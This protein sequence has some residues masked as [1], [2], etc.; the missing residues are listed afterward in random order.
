MSTVR[1]PASVVEILR[2]EPEPPHEFRVA[3][4]RYSL[5]IP[6][7]GVTFEID[8]LRREK[9]ELL[10][11][12]AVLCDLPGVR[13]TNGTLSIADFNVSS[14][15][16]RIERAK[17][18]QS[19]ANIKGLDWAGLLEEFCQRVLYADRAGQPAVDLRTLPKPQR[20]DLLKIDG[21]V[22][23]RNHASILFGD[24]G[25]FKSYIALYVAGKLYRSGINVAFFDWELDGEQHRERLER[26][27]GAD[28]PQVLYA[29]C[30]KPLVYDVDRLGRIVRENR[31]QFAVYDSVAFACDGPPEAAEVAGRYFRA[32]R[33]IGCGSLHIAHITKGE[34]ADK[35]PFGSTFWHNGARSTWYAKRTDEDDGESATVGLFHRKANLTKLS[36]PTGFRIAFAHERTLFER[37]NIADSPELAE[38]LS[39]RQRMQHLLK[40]GAMSRES[41]AE[42]LGVTMNNIRQT[43]YHNKHLF[44]VLK[45]GKVGL[46]EKGKG[47]I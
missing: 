5:T 2:R 24:G 42:E 23:P 11:E 17:L 13:S 12:L 44:T 47:V 10:G 4:D 19:R 6:A 29:R 37:I 15:R 26:I 41:I 22:L 35:K 45:G 40:Q 39:L 38:N 3:D 30:D 18:L 27:F 32:V 25:A 14:A 43:I 34:N 16:A 1:I 28:M 21:L 9:H 7:Y 46:L 20:D 36:P 8:R 31:I 33:Q